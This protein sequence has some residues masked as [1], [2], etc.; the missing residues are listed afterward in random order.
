MSLYQKTRRAL[1]TRGWSYVIKYGLMRIKTRLFI[2]PPAKLRKWIQRKV[3]IPKIAAQ[4]ES[5][6]RTM[7]FSPNPLVTVRIATYQN[8]KILVERT[9]PSILNQTYQNF[10]VV[11]VGDGITS[12]QA[13]IVE[14]WIAERKD[15]RIRFYN[16]PERGKYPKNPRK[17]WWVAGTTPS[18]KGLD[19]A[20][21]EW[22]AP[23]DD[24]DEFTPGHIEEMLKF[25]LENGLEV[26]YGKIMM[27]FADGTWIERGSEPFRVG[28][29]CHLGVM[30]HKR[31]GFLRYDIQSYKYGEPGDW[32]IWRRMQD[33]GAVIGFFPSVVGIHYKEFTRLGK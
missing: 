29:V 8:S 11:I 32:N 30:Y 19:M 14:K 13:E 1:K 20:R 5:N 15:E 3:E 4:L 16:L 12:D 18:N 9:L 26:V 27:E 17:R 25:A 24:D 6:R 33:A 28:H 23:L 21:G 22:I 7:G 10:E 2:D 31:L